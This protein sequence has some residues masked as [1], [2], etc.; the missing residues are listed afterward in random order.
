MCNP[1]SVNRCDC[2]Q[3]NVRT[4]SVQ[5][6]GVVIQR[7]YCSCE[8]RCRGT[9]LLLVGSKHPLLAPSSLLTAAV[10]HSKTHFLFFPGLVLWQPRCISTSSPAPSID[11]S[12]EQLL[13][14]DKVMFWVLRPSRLRGA[15]RPSAGRTMTAVREAEGRL[16]KAKAQ[17]YYCRRGHVGPVRVPGPCDVRAIWFHSAG[18]PVLA[19]AHAELCID[20]RVPLYETLT[21]VH[22]DIMQAQLWRET[23][24][25][26][27]VLM[28]LAFASLETSPVAK[29]GDKE[30]H[31]QKGYSP[32]I[33]PYCLFSRNQHKF[34]Y[35]LKHRSKHLRGA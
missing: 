29:W 3:V 17:C 11:G 16:K 5:R 33:S 14:R 26:R 20:H 27:N 35:V 7:L 6:R 9:P 2:A 22:H 8:A 1:F 30:D 31:L 10:T 15:A 28:K 19:R 4:W 18:L 25:P 23:Q 24:P 34:I 21:K 32:L 12:R 13:K